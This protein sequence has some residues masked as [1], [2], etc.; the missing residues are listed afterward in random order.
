VSESFLFFFYFFFS[1][2]RL[3]AQILLPWLLDVLFL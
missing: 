3:F 2:W 1:L